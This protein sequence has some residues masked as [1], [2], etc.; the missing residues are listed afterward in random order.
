MAEKKKKEIEL[1]IAKKKYEKEKLEI[2]LKYTT[3][4]DEN[5]KKNIWFKLENN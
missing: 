3:D 5:N 4:E 1:K 2:E